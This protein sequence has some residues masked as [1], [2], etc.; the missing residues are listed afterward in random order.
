MN[1]ENDW[2]H[3]FD[4][5]KKEQLN[6]YESK[7]YFQVYAR[8]LVN[9]C[10]YGFEEGYFLGYVK[11]QVAFAFMSLQS[12]GFPVKEHSLNLEMSF[13]QAFDLLH[14]TRSK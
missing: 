12:M 11:S 1:N 10:S 14:G 6:M 4:S 9:K 13:D 3:I 7:G 5:F 8:E 2:I